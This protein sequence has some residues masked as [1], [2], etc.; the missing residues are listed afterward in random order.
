M[1]ISNNFNNFNNFNNVNNVNKSNNI[2]IFFNYEIFL[3]SFFIF[4][5]I[6]LIDVFLCLLF[7]N[8]S[9][10]YQLHTAINFLVSKEIIF[11]VFKLFFYPE[12]AYLEPVSSIPSLYIIIIHIYHILFFYNLKYMDY[13]HHIT[14][15]SLGVLPCLIF[16]NS[17][18][19]YLAFIACFG[20]PGIFE[21]FI[22]SLQKHNKILLIKQKQINSYMYICFRHPLCIIGIFNNILAYKKG[23][24]NDNLFL[25]I[26]LNGLLYCN[27]TLFNYLTLS[28]Y[29]KLLTF[30]KI[31]NNI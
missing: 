5:K 10:W 19:S 14:F 31:K 8:K 16:T 15:V 7:S 11:D 22:L 29:I 4:N 21:Y 24:L 9:R 23:Y 25:T 18:Q 17:K 12:T 13:F 20:I 28:S 1:M 2:N 3:N 6:C 27:G 26:Y 30:N